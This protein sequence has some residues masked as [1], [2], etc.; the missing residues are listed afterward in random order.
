MLAWL[1]PQETAAISAHSLYTI[2]P[3]TMSLHAKPHSKVYVCLAVACRLHF[4][5]NDRDLL[6]ATAMTARMIWLSPL[7]AE[8]PY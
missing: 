3:C 5:Q 4:W 7:E 8:Q 1:V 2:Q 6:R